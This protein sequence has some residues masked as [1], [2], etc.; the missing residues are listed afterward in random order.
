MNL[1]ETKK[2]ESV[3]T[4]RPALSAF[5]FSSLPQLLTQELKRQGITYEEMAMQIG[6]SSS[7]FKRMIANPSAARA[8]NLHA[9]LKE[10]GMM[11][12]LEK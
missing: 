11:L 9:L 7:T 12:W 6:V 10:L 3:S 5:D 1:G 4:S 8:G 2:Q